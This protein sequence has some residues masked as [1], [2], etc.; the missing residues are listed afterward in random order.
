MD[1]RKEYFH[2]NS[3]YNS[4]LNSSMVDD[5]KFKML[6][7]L[8]EVLAKDQIENEY[9]STDKAPPLLSTTNGIVS[10]VLNSDPSMIKST[11]YA[12]P[13]SEY[14]LKESGVPFSIL[15]TP[16][17]DKSSISIFEDA[18]KCL[19]CRSF[20]SKL[21]I[22]D[23][24]MLKCAICK[25]PMIVL[26]RG[27]LSCASYDIIIDKA[28]KILPIFLFIIDV[29]S[30][31][32]AKNAIQGIM[33]ILKNEN[34]LY[35]YKNVV[36]LILDGGITTFYHE[37]DKIYVVKMS[38][39]EAPKFSKN[40]VIDTTNTNVLN[41]IMS[42]ITNIQF[43]G[44]TS[45]TICF[46]IIKDI[47]NIAPTKIAFFTNM[48]SHYNYE[49]FLKYN[50][51]SCFNL[52][53]I[54]SSNTDGDSFIK[55]AFY[56]GGRVF[57]YTVNNIDCIND[58]FQVACAKSVF[59]IR[60]N[61]KVSG[62]LVKTDVIA[63][64]LNNNLSNLFLNHMDTNTTIMYNLTLGDPSLENK[65]LQAEIGY[66][67]FDGYKKV[68]ILNLYLEVNKNIYPKMSVDAIF[69]AFVKIKLD[70][71]VNLDNELVR[72]LSTYRYKNKV[73]DEQMVLPET[74]K[75]LPV[76]IQSYKKL[77]KVDTMFVFNGNVE[78]VLKYFYPRLISL[79]DFVINPNCTGI[80]LSR[81]NII[82]GEVY[83]LENSKDI[84]FYLTR[85]VEK[86]LIKNIFVDED[87]NQVIT[88]ESFNP[89]TEEGAVCINIINDIFMKYNYALNISVLYP[90]HL[91][92]A[93]FIRYMVEDA[94]NDEP[95]YLDYIYKLHFAIKDSIGE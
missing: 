77:T 6:P 40:Y 41:S 54:N 68:R 21:T 59:Q 17:N 48:Q 1:S 67:D 22:S 12:V 20:A 23:Q 85:K 39:E 44:K 9:Y 56:S 73:K 63:P 61:L 35:L 25:Q 46:D 60:I 81:R 87:L 43:Y 91:N 18:D 7:N 52:F 15:L 93:Q 95:N 28:S 75:I 62:N 71:D 4:S 86:T 50:K 26:N 51:N 5:N 19:S 92:E 47:S 58:L 55:L 29:S 42:Y 8:P 3:A 37:N 34:F 70:D 11:L 94:M 80:R 49:E 65:I 33:L 83:V 82:D 88:R 78:Q 30:G 13:P 14:L 31:I 38:G 69:A 45:E 32:L 53:T 57:K 2:S 36:F 64:S 76:L 84:I 16:F 90:G 24:N 10:E 66:I 79:S 89:A 72:I 27:V 74:L